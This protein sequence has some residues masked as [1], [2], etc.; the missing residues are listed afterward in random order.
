MQAMADWLRNDLPSL[1]ERHGVPAAAVGFLVGG[2]ITT[3]AAGVLHLG[4]GVTA[5]TDSLFQ[6]GS[7]TKVVTT[8]LVMQLVDEG[9]IDLDAPIRQYLPELHLVD[10]AAASVITTRHLLSHQSG[11]E[12]DYF[13]DT[14]RGD[15]CIEKF[16]ATLIK[17]PQLFEPGTQFSYS[18]AGFV[19]LGRL[20]EVLRGAPYDVVLTERLLTPLRLSHAAP[21]PYEAIMHRV[22]QG[23]VPSEENGKLV[24]APIWA[25]PRSNSPAGATLAM[26]AED[27]L[28]FA[29]L[30][31]NGGVSNDGER[32]LSEESV[33][34]MRERHI[35]VPYVGLL[36]EAW[37]LGW[38]LDNTPAGLMV[39]HDGS[40]V[41]QNAFLRLLPEHGIAVA[42]LTNGGDTFALSREI[43]EA[44]FARFTGTN[45]LPVLPVP[46]DVEASQV[47]TSLFLGTYSASA[48][49][50]IVSRDEKDQLWVEPVLKGELAEVDTAPPKEL[51][52]PYGESGLIQVEPAKGGAHFIY[53]FLNPGPDGRFQ[54][55]HTS[56]ALQRSR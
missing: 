35:D 45:V 14:G 26:N 19:V 33:A 28:V 25:L 8:T 49:D 51:V 50:V 4:T 24:P 42:V 13:T 15:D 52:T 36:G 2:E 38:E 47:D 3:T 1:I 37:G 39:S 10:E 27:L 54:T 43:M 44:V 53:A 12:G 56:R 31:T 5:D 9:L 17:A 40:T 48:L 55:L 11:F 41:G 18:N 21:G 6:I 29:K 32:L 7:I 22:A 23:H 20:I 46:G 30:H 16:V 34:A